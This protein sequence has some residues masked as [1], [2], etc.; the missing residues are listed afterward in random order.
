VHSRGSGAYLVMVTDLVRRRVWRW[1][2]LPWF[3]LFWVSAAWCLG[4]WRGSW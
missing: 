1:C 2:D 3:L 4:K